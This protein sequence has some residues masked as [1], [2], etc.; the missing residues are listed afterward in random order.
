MDLTTWAC[1]DGGVDG[2]L[3]VAGSVGGVGG[4]AQQSMNV[5][6]SE[7]SMCA[8]L[9]RSTETVSLCPLISSV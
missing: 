9:S 2:A 5:S 8:G 1:R 6:L 3:V 4:C 7:R